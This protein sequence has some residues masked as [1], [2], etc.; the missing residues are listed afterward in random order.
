[1]QTYI[2]IYIQ[3]YNHEQSPGM[4]VP[5]SL[6]MVPHTQTFALSQCLGRWVSHGR[7]RYLV[8]V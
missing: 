4:M 7:F 6:K 5:Q 2:Y 3:N 1:M 8:G